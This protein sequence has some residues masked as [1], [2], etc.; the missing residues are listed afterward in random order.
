[1]HVSFEVISDGIIMNMAVEFFF[2]LNWGPGQ[3]SITHFDY[4]FI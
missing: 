2:F 4:V 3:N 1:M